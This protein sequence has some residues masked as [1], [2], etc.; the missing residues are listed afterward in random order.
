MALSKHQDIELVGAVENNLEES[1]F[2]EYVNRTLSRILQ[3]H[4]AYLWGG[5]VRDPVV[6][7]MYGNGNIPE[8][9]DFDVL[10]DDSE[11]R[12]DFKK[13]LEGLGEMYQTRFMS[14]KLRLVNGLEIDVAPFSNSSRLLNGENLPICLETVLTG[15]EFTSSA[16]AYRLRD[17]TIYSN[18]AIES[19]RSKEI[20]LLYAYEA[21]HILMSRLVLHER[22]LNFTIGERAKRLVVDNYSPE[23]DKSIREYLEYKK[24]QDDFSF[25]VERLREIKNNSV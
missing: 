9:R 22:R 19:I 14:S 16:L 3:Y 7:S 6:K 23:L 15:C 12:I 2:H 11:G 4:D 13:L 17:R 25:V 21:P 18:G 8:T 5:S 24:L 1:R 10:V 20:E